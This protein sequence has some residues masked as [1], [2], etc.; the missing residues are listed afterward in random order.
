MEDFYFDI[1]R[2]LELPIVVE[3]HGVMKHKFCLNVCASDV[4]MH[5]LL[6]HLPYPYQ[7][8]LK[9]RLFYVYRFCLTYAVLLT[10]YGTNKQY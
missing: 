9:V 1:R 7:P 2:I 4:Y 3:P 10:I 6:S 5:Q 8:L